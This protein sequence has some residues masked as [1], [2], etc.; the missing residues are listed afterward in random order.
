MVGKNKKMRKKVTVYRILSRYHCGVAKVIGVERLLK[1]NDIGERILVSKVSSRCVYSVTC[2]NEM[3]V[4]KTRRLFM[5]YIFLHSR[6]FRNRST[7]RVIDC[8]HFVKHIVLHSISNWIFILIIMIQ[9][10]NN[11]LFL[12][13]YNIILHYIYIVQHDWTCLY[14]IWYM[15][16]MLLT[17]FFFLDVRTKKT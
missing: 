1:R 13:A 15:I 12:Y 16:C 6:I 4:K 8:W 5:N 11:N 3:N 14:C 17:I 9:E 10:R 2:D 7:Y